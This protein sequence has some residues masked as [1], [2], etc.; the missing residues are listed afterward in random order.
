MNFNHIALRTVGIINN[1]LKNSKIL[2]IFELDN[3]DFFG[4]VQG[5]KGNMKTISSK[6][7]VEHRVKSPG[8]IITNKQSRQ[9]IPVNPGDGTVFMPDIAN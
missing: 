3:L 1:W 2:S 5:M 6:V 4:L 7:N 8:Y 9:I